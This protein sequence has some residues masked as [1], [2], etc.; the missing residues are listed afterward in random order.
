[1][2]APRCLDVEWEGINTAAATL[3]FPFN[4]RV[5]LPLVL[6]ISMSLQ[7]H[8]CVT[9]KLRVRRG[10]GKRYTVDYGSGW[11]MWFS[12]AGLN[13]EERKNTFWIPGLKKG[14]CLSYPNFTMPGHAFVL[15][16]TWCEWEQNQKV[17]PPWTALV[18]FLSHAV[19]TARDGTCRVWRMDGTLTWS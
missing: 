10:Q 7:S 4:R 16:L 19:Q 1:M 5:L 14:V 6:W 12:L 15:C 3:C 17:L 13:A 2:I 8:G 9:S 11:A 18:S